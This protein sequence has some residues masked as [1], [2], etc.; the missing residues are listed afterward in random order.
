M[1][2][3]RSLQGKIQEVHSAAIQDQ[4]A[5]PHPNVTLLYTQVEV[6]AAIRQVQATLILV[7]IFW[8]HVNSVRSSQRMRSYIDY[9][10]MTI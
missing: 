10:K 9:E 5:D 8:I 3:I 2:K 4:N 7:L 6:Q 1:S